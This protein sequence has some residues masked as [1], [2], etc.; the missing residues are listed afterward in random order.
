MKIGDRVRVV[1]NDKEICIG[2]FYNVGDVGIIVDAEEIEEDNYD[3]QFD[4]GSLRTDETWWITG[5]SLELIKEE[6]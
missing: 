5:K 4:E 3:V 1:A 6:K 2:T